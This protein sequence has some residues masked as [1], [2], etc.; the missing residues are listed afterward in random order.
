MEAGKLAVLPRDRW[1]AVCEPRVKRDIQAVRH[2]L[3]GGQE[4]GGGRW[5]RTRDSGSGRP[6]DLAGEARAPGTRYPL[7]RRP[8]GLLG[9]S[10]IGGRGVPNRLAVLPMEGADAETVRRALRVDAAEIPALSPPGAPDSS[11]ARPRRSAG[12]D[13]RT[14]RQLMLTEGT[15]GGFAR[16]VEEI[17]ERRR[18]RVGAGPSP[19]SHPPADPLGPLRQAARDAPAAHRP[20]Q[21]A[22]RSAPRPSARHPARLRRRARRRSGTISWKRPTWPPRPAS[23][24]S[25]SRPATATSFPRPWPPTAARTA[26][27][28]ARSRT[29]PA[30][31]L[32]I[33]RQIREEAPGLLVTSRLSAT[34]AVPVPLRLRHGPRRTGEDRSHRDEG[35]RRPSRP[36]RRPLPGAL[37]GHSGLEAAHRPAVRSAPPRRQRPREA[38]ARGRRPPSR[39]RDGDPAVGRR[40][41]PSSARDIPGSA[42]FGPGVGAAMVAAGRSAAFGLGRGALAYPDFA[43]DLLSARP[44][45]LSQGLHDVFALLVPPPPAEAGRMCRP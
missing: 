16:L 30:L 17:R 24:A 7:S 38:P 3:G 40:G 14:P 29:G 33:V 43:A 37:A 20:E 32:E 44:P 27:T 22:S 28:A 8:S 9:K 1:P 18:K 35:P 12:T 42:A 41:S 11:G 31:L 15:L 19:A 4:V 25:T 34:D 26:A 45:L 5:P 10:S 21:P 6:D 23:T 36:G 13:S 2:I 39:R